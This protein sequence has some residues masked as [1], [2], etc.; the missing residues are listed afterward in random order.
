MNFINY[1]HSND[2][3]YLPFYILH[4][5]LVHNSFIIINSKVK[6][7]IILFCVGRLKGTTV[8]CLPYYA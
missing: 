8:L 5:V 4:V 3:I 1:M 2:I 6:L 7:H